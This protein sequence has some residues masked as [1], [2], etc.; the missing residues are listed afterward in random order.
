MV[1][2]S[3]EEYVYRINHLKPYLT[4]SYAEKFLDSIDKESFLGQME[5]KKKDVYN[6]VS[7]CSRNIFILKELEKKFLS[8]DAKANLAEYLERKSVIPQ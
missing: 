7:G 6:V 2:I 1:K 5:V 8:E 4:G 3:K